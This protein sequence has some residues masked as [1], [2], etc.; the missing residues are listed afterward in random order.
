MRN[1]SNKPVGSIL[2]DTASLTVGRLFN[3]RIEPDC[4]LKFILYLDGRTSC[5]V[6]FLFISAKWVLAPVMK[7]PFL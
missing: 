7:A 4:I 3:Y 2:K 5:F 1:L 6:P